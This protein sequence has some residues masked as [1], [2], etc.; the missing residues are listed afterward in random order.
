MG[1]QKN[2]LIGELKDFKGKISKTMPIEKL[3]FFGSRAYGHPHRDS[4]VD[5]MVVSK[6]FSNQ[7]TLKRAPSL[8]LTWNLDYPVDFLCYTPEEFRRLKGKSSFIREIADK[9]IQI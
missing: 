7:N 6:I 2:D 4:D 8:Y 3:I 9:G 5:L 1:K